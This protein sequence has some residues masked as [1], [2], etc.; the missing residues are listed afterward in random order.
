MEA[1]AIIRKCTPLIKYKELVRKCLVNEGFNLDTH[2]TKLTPFSDL[3]SVTHGFS[4]LRVE[5]TCKFVID[6]NIE[7]SLCWKVCSNTN[8]LWFMCILYMI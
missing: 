3:R 1:T 4:I 7:V 2:I 8:I 5:R 6:C